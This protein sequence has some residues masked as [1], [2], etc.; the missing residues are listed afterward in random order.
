MQKL[1]ITSK[2][3]LIFAV[4]TF[5]LSSCQ[6]NKLF[7]ETDLNG[8]E[9]LTFHE[10]NDDDAQQA[11][12][13]AFENGSVQNLRVSATNEDASILGCATV[14]RDTVNKKITI[15]FGSG[16]TGVDGRTRSGKI[17]VSYTGRYKTPGSVITITTDGYK[18]DNNAVEIHRTVTNNGENN[19]GN[20]TFTIVSHRMVTHTD[21]STS[22]SNVNKVREWVEGDLTPGVFSD[23]VYKVTGT[24]THTS[25]N[26]ILY[27]FSTLTDLTRKISCHQFSAGELKIIRHAQ[28]ERTAVVNY[29][30]GECDGTATVTLD[31]GKVYTINLRRR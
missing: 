21:G 16:C 11:S 8:A 4:V 28:R 10:S 24:G 29:G 13:E 15:D 3:L 31:N 25:K 27:D 30:N 5:G 26:G 23:D 17:L 19:N 20:L 6:K 12:D 18:V 7:D 1:I 22:E 2:I 9:N 14:T